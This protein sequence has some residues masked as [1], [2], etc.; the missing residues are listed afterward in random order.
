MICAPLGASVPPGAGSFAFFFAFYLGTAPWAWLGVALVTPLV[1]PG[2][3]EA[4]VRESAPDA[5]P[6]PAEAEVCFVFDALS[7][8]TIF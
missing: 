8:I 6:G 5:V 4:G 3:V 1:P 2:A 7:V